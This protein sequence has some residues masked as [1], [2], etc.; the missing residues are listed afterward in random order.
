MNFQ[1]EFYH[2]MTR[3]KANSRANQHKHRKTKLS[4]LKHRIY[5]DE[6]GNITNSAPDA[7]KWRQCWQCDLVGV[8]ETKQEIELRYT[9]RS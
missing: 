5:L 9:N 1:E 2:V 7:D 3:L 4:A 6:S 8:Y